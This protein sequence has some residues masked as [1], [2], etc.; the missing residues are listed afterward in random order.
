M[1]AEI[2]TVQLVAFVSGVPTD[3][4]NA[5]WPRLFQHPLTGFSTMSPATVATGLINGVQVQLHVQPTRFDIIAT[6]APP[7]GLPPSALP[8]SL[9]DFASTL[10][11]MR[12][13]FDT[14]CSQNSTVRLACVVQTVEQAAS[15]NDA[16][17]QIAAAIPL[18]VKPN[19]GDVTFQINVKKASAVQPGMDLNRLCRWSTA[20]IM[21][22]QLPIQGS[23][24]GLNVPF[25]GAPVWVS[26]GYFD[27]NTTAGTAI[28]S[29]N[30]SSL[31]DE[32]IQEA[33]NI[34]G[35]G[36]AYL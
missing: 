26:N 36:Y 3:N 12:P 21:M 25:S 8:P 30:A 1:P 10:A 2:E 33:K 35:G 19:S 20:S 6:G 27:I 16:S 13:A 17:A 28:S 23:P 31:M 24:A 4:A 7:T 18:N 34:L 15:E 14:I 11:L 32:L 5:W 29:G 22:M 9:S